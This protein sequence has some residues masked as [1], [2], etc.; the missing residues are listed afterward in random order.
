MHSD[1]SDTREKESTQAKTSVFCT[2]NLGVP[3]PVAGDPRSPDTY[4]EL[5]LAEGPCARPYGCRGPVRSGSVITEITENAFSVAARKGFPETPL[6]AWASAGL[7]PARTL[8]S[9]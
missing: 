8:P 4:L 5:K 9:R 3:P 1:Y 2:T 7:H 6:S